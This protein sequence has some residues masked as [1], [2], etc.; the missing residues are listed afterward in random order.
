MFANKSA[1]RK[2]ILLVESNDELAELL[3]ATIVQKT[4]YG[5]MRVS[6]AA[7]ALLALST[8]IPDLMILNIQLSDMAGAD[9]SA[10]IRRDEKLR[11]LPLLFV[12][13]DQ[14]MEEAIS[15]NLPLQLPVFL[16][17]LAYLLDA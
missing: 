7:Q 9:L 15:L 4:G 2:I 3:H 13:T 12:G 16:Q 17:T 5:T 8:V 1:R 6:T 11:K 14:P 10:Q